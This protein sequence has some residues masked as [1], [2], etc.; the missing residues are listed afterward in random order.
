MALWAKMKGIDLLETGDFTHP[1]QLAEIRAKL[2][3]TGDGLYHLDGIRFVL[4]I[5]VNC[6]AE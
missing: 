3:Q 6:S 1:D 4:G 2:H 5:E